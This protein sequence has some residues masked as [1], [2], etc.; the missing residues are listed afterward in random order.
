MSKREFKKGQ[1]VAILG[2]VITENWEEGEPVDIVSLRD[3][4]I[5]ITDNEFTVE[6]EEVTVLTKALEKSLRKLNQKEQRK[7]LETQLALL[8]KTFNAE[9]A[10]LVARLDKLK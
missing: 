6:P 2:R 7:E 10:D 1:V 3:E 9:R 8:T 4:E 5:G